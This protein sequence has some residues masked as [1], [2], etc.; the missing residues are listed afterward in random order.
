MAVHKDGRICDVHIMYFGDKGVEAVNVV[1]SDP[2]DD[3]EDFQSELWHLSDCHIC[4]STGYLDSEGETVFGGQWSL[5][6]THSGT[7]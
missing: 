4:G 5:T 1:I 3:P 7:S 2:D 6:W